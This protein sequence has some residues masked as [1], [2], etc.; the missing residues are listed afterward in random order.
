MHAQTSPDRRSALAVIATWWPLALTGV[1][2]AVPIGGIV[3]STRRQH[4]A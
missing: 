1:G 4:H 3:E 2:I